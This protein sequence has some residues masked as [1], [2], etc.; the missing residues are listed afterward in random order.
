MD[1]VIYVNT[2]LGHT[3][4]S[5]LA[6]MAKASGRAKGQQLRVIL[7]ERLGLSS[8]AEAPHAK[9][10]RRKATKSTRKS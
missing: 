1:S 2:P 6:Q 3:E 10:L 9:L 8:G 5:L 7:L 4:H